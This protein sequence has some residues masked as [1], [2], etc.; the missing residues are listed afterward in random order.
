MASSTASQ[1]YHVL[2]QAPTSIPTHN[3]PIVL[4]TRF[5]TPLDTQKPLPL[6]TLET[7]QD[8]AKL[9][10]LPQGSN[11]K[12][13]Q[14]GTTARK[15]PSVSFDELPLLNPVVQVIQSDSPEK[16]QNGEG[17]TCHL[18]KEDALRVIG[19]EFKKLQ[20]DVL[21]S[22]KSAFDLIDYCIQL[23]ESLVLA[24]DKDQRLRD[25]IRAYLIFN[26][27]INTFI[28]IHFNGFGHFMEL[29][30][31]DFI[32]YLNLYNFFNTDD[33]IGADKFNVNLKVLRN[34]ITHYLNSRNLLSFDV[35][36]LFKWLD[37]YVEFMS[38][39]EQKDERDE[40]LEPNVSFSKAE[41]GKVSEGAQLD[42][43]DRKD[44][45]EEPNSGSSVYKSLD[46]LP[47]DMHPDLE[48]SDDDLIFVDDLDDFGARFPMLP[49]SRQNSGHMKAK[50]D[51]NDEENR[52]SRVTSETPY[53]VAFHAFDG[54]PITE[55][56]AHVKSTDFNKNLAGQ[57]SELSFFN[58]RP[59]FTDA[60]SA[61]KNDSYVCIRNENN[62]IARDVGMT[63][64]ENLP[65]TSHQLLPQ[66]T[67]Q[68][69]PINNSLSLASSSSNYQSA[70]RTHANRHTMA[71]TNYKL[72]QRPHTIAVSNN[73]SATWQNS[74]QNGEAQNVN[75][76][77][78]HGFHQYKPPPLHPQQRLN[79]LQ[80]NVQNI[81]HPNEIRHA[82]QVQMSQ[83]PQV[84]QWQMKQ[85]Q[86]QQINM[87]PIQAPS[88]SQMFSGQLQP[89]DP[90]SAQH[91][92]Q[93]LYVGKPYTSPPKERSFEIIKQLGICGLKNHGSTCYINLILQVLAG[94]PQL[95]NFLVV[96]SKRAKFGRLS[97]AT[98]YLLE[99][100]RN[101]GGQTINPINFLTVLSFS[102]PA[103]NIPFAQQDA[104]ELLL[105][106]LD[107][108][109]EENCSIQENDDIDYLKDWK[110]DVCAR[111]RKAYLDWYKDLVK[112]EQRSM[113]NNI[114][115][116]HLQDKLRCNTCGYESV[117]Y[118]LFTILSLPIPQ[119]SGR[120]VKLED[121]LNHFTKDEVMYGENAWKCPECKKKARAEKAN[122]EEDVINVVFQQKK[123][124]WS[125]KPTPKT[126]TK[127]ASKGKKVKS[128]VDVDLKK[129]M[130]SPKFAIKSLSFIKL[131]PVL[132]IQLSRFSMDERADKLNTDILYPVVLNFNNENHVI[133]YSLVGLINHFGTLKSGH[134]TALVNKGLATNEG[135]GPFW[136]YFDDDKVQMVHSHGIDHR[137]RS[138]IE[139]SR[140]I[141]VLCYIRN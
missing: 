45:R 32:I 114:F 51:K 4:K 69:I 70:E 113:F 2:T 62:G 116:G 126:D 132:F 118:S 131:P 112:R 38:S 18:G 77:Q 81:T 11:K 66:I 124:F 96:C 103:L 110:I 107:K 31:K 63:S 10:L 43:T 135:R 74:Y 76:W 25:Y 108:F 106:I 17:E 99:A 119:I 120:I 64:Y 100:M 57:S 79:N 47:V 125:K 59:L 24:K 26:Y 12:P 5:H 84:I 75:P 101:K 137:G 136:C 8:L 82:N 60:E 85:V 3:G 90:R 6:L 133:S 7:G 140:D 37:K 19:K 48:G 129:A 50:D 73:S 128:M 92:P 87:A 86:S 123:S 49:N 102:N 61:K 117:L 9:S 15:P 21:L 138:R 56:I 115:Q 141:Y 130:P 23:F 36:M 16:L 104:Q 27:F 78:D 83:Q 65:R 68:N 89:F 94:I 98:M 109:H 13:D 46:R 34:L 127:A 44:D 28:I 71:P 134:Y 139:H 72:I 122:D 39:D 88:N 95:L 30:R 35:D 111:D 29:A 33:I 91:Q 121:C 58:D 80:M 20:L 67:S 42:D 55:S 22:Q 52:Q 93:Y 40:S 14:N 1:E 105:F 97:R 54:S 41:M 53:P